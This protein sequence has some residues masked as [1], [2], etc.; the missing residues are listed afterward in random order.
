MDWFVLKVDFRKNFDR[1]V[2]LYRREG[3]WSFFRKGVPYIWWRLKRN[4]A[5]AVILLFPSLEWRFSLVYS[6]RLWGKEGD[7]S[8]AGS[9]LENTAPAVTFLSSI[10]NE[11]GI[12]TMADLG[13]GG[14]ALVAAGL[15]D[16]CPGLRRYVGLEIAPAVVQRNKRR[17]GTP[18]VT[19]AKADLTK[20]PLP[21]VELLVLREVLWHL[22]NE[23][24]LKVL[25]QCLATGAT[26]LCVS[27]AENPKGPFNRPKMRS[28]DYQ[29]VVLTAPPY[30]FPAPLCKGKDHVGGMAW[31]YLY[32]IDTLRSVL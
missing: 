30:N 21:E 8:G 27:S 18:Q 28:S 11:R 31:L 2:A 32:E 4:T 23:D 5:L 1:A 25:R 29:A 10:I 14:G 20:G 19:F 7:G 13:C 16:K 24:A 12:E 3:L 22:S 6:L 15:L 17:Y 26:Y 9:S